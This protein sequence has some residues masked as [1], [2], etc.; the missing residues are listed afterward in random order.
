[1]IF[2]NAKT[3]LVRKSFYSFIDVSILNKKN[4]KARYFFVLFYCRQTNTLTNMNV[5][6]LHLFRI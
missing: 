1:V 3:Q 2:E 5:L 4:P 6:S